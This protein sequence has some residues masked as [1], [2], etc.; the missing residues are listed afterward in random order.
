MAVFDVVYIVLLARNPENFPQL[1]DIS[2]LSLD[3]R[4]SFDN[5]IHHWL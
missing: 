2:P 1:L 4:A 5:F 3:N